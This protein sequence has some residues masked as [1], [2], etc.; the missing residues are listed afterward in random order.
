MRRGAMRAFALSL[1]AAL[2]LGACERVERGEGKADATK[3][4]VS[5]TE[6][7][8]GKYA[9][10]GVPAKLKAGLV[11]ITLTNNGKASHE[12]QL[13]RIGAGHTVEEVKTFFETEEEGDPIPEYLHGAGGL[14]EIAAGHTASSTM[15]LTAGSYVY[16]CLV[17][18]DPAHWQ[19]GM[20]GEFEVEGSS[21]AAV[22]ETTASV[23]A[24]EYQFTPAGLKAGKNTITFANGGKELHHLL[25]V[26]IAGDAT[27]DQIRTF[28][29]SEGEPEGPPPVNFEEATGTAVID[30][31]TSLVTEVELKTGRYLFVCFLRDRA[32]GP[33]HAEKGM[34]QEFAIF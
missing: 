33:S 28:F 6:P 3:V 19:A 15:L 26:P 12:I 10:A 21:D 11:E 7:S 18:E 31:G 8:A 14:P 9:F 4:A 23:S 25:M 34:F 27:L 24:K 17:G 5:A 1:G 13:V 30:G 29:Q 22:P 20:L 32:G 2:L 16:L